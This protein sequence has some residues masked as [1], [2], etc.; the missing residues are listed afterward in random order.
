MEGNELARFENHIKTD[1]RALSVTNRGS[2]FSEPNTGTNLSW[3]TASN[4]ILYKASP[5][6]KIKLILVASKL[7]AKVLNSVSDD[8]YETHLGAD[9]VD[10]WDSRQGTCL[11]TWFTW[12][13]FWHLNS[14]PKSAT[15][16]PCAPPGVPDPQLHKHPVGKIKSGEFRH[17]LQ[18]CLV[19]VLFPVSV[20]K[21]PHHRPSRPY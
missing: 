15:S 6:N 10:R 14:C 8:H 16:D 12:V 18:L 19:Q 11:C 2:L 17:N 13:Q 21:P 4:L 20:C 9:A 7:P 5:C 3:N 1:K